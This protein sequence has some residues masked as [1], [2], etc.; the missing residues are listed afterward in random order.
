MEFLAILIVLGLLQLWGSGGP[1]QRDR[2]FYTLS[3]SVKGM[4]IAPHFRLLLVV[5]L[6]ML[7]LLLLL[8]QS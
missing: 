8:D 4:V 3:Q 1:L 5:G 6:P 2:W 7:L